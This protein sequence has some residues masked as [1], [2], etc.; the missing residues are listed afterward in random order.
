MG[1]S[2]TIRVAFSVA[3]GRRFLKERQI[4]SLESVLRLFHFFLQALLHINQIDPLSA[5]TRS[6][7]QIHRVRI[8]LFFLRDNELVLNH[9][10]S[11]GH[12]VPHRFWVFRVPF[13]FISS[14]VRVP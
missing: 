1:R 2:S 5:A 8:I 11:V 9:T 7:K 4:L 6:F 12:S 13:T 14:F 10:G 3:P